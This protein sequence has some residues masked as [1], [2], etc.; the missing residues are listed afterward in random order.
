VS[1]VAADPTHWVS[2]PGLGRNG[3]DEKFLSYSGESCYKG[4]LE[5][6]ETVSESSTLLAAQRMKGLRQ[7]V[8]AR[9]RLPVLRVERKTIHGQEVD[10][11]ILPTEYAEGAL[12]SPS[13]GAIL[14]RRYAIIES[15]LLDSGGSLAGQVIAPC[16]GCA[17]PSPKGHT[18][19]AGG[20]DGTR[21]SQ[22]RDP[23]RAGKRAARADCGGALQDTAQR[24][25]G[26]SGGRTA[27]NSPAT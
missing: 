8:L 13:R 18:E 9:D 23:S 25:A 15:I 20:R 11:R 16:A 3:S 6:G 22:P 21:A 5:D 7:R 12:A 26:A 27:A 1:A 14:P 10:V 4:R 19:D 2:T 24:A 17:R